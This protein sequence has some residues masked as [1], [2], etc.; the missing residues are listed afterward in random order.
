MTIKSKVR[1]VSRADVAKIVGVA[2][3]T[4]SLVLNNTPNTR[5]RDKV[6]QRIH[7]VANE[8]GY[9]P[10]ATARALVTGRTNSIAVVIFQGGNPFDT[11]TNMILRSFWDRIH[12]EKYRIIVDSI[13][14]N[15]DASEFFVDHAADGILLVAPPPD[16]KNLSIMQKAE[17]PLV[18]VGNIPNSENVDYVD[19]DNYSASKKITEYLIKQGHRKIVHIGGILEQSST[20]LE[21]LAG[22]RDALLGAGIDYDPSN[23]FHGEF[24]YDA[25]R[26]GIKK[27]IA[28]NNDFTA[29]FA[30]CGDSAYGAIDEL[31]A[32]D[33]SVPCDV[34]IAA[35]KSLTKFTGR[36][37]ELTGI[38]NPLKEIGKIAGELL[39]QRVKGLKGTSVEQRLTGELFI[40]NTV[41]KL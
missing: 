31:E 22:Y 18:C 27:F 6:R 37:C 34:S 26:E 9:R 33:I 16:V 11:Y 32:H 7:E 19:L 35:I 5:V 2:P 17:F 25:G 8:L 30:A 12:H 21:R 20:A 24:I 41:R 38:I 15:A 23:V 1:R 10:S 36:R 3:C 40:G 29:I 4:V 39:F 14:S 13:E 28:D